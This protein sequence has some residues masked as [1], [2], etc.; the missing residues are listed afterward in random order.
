MWRFERRSPPRSGFHEG[1]VVLV[2]LH[3]VADKALRARA[4]QTEVSRLTRSNQTR[5][6]LWFFGLA[7]AVSWALW[8]PAVMASFGWIGP[9]TSSWAH[10]SRQRS[11]T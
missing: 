11:R 9:W 3:A 4:S 2:T 7:Y 6:V 8:S 10:Q 5:P 1:V